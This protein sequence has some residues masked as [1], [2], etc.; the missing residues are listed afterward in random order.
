MPQDHAFQFGLIGDTGYSTEGIE[1]L[2]RLLASI[3]RGGP[4]IFV[5]VSDFESD[6]RAYDSDSSAGPMPCTDERFPSR[7]TMRFRASGVQSF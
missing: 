4:C 2:S 3:R 1:G 5:H 6:R 7:S